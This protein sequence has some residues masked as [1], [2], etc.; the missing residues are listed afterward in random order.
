MDNKHRKLLVNKQSEGCKAISPMHQNTSGGRAPPGPAGGAY[1]LPRPT[2]CNGVY[3]YI[4][5]GKGGKGPA[6]KGREGRGE[7]HF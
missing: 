6:C 5:G 4:K 7:A 1:A 3:F 2:S